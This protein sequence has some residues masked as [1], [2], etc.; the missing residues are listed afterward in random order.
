[1]EKR[2]SNPRV[3]SQDNQQLVEIQNGDWVLCNRLG[4]E[5]AGRIIEINH[6][7]QKVYI[8]VPES[9]WWIFD[10]HTP[11]RGDTLRIGYTFKQAE[12]NITLIPEAIA[13]IIN[14]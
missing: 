11:V 7:D 13:T 10:R 8:E 5:W 3:R 6:I 4:I 1:M 14:S 2:N 9:K 12:P